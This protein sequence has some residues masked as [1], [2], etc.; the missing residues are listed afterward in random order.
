VV[1]PD[2]RISDVVGLSPASAGVLFAPV[3]EPIEQCLPEGG[4]LMRV[5]LAATPGG[6]AFE[7]D[8]D[9]EVDEATRRCVLEAL[10]TADLDDVMPGAVSPTDTP[11]R[12]ESQLTIRW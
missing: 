2:I 3:T 7:V 8:P 12:I 6:T 11:P 4:G 5:R 10:S 9:T 1:G